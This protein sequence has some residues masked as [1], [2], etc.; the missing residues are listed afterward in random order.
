V[1]LVHCDSGTP[2]DAERNKVLAESL[3]VL[4]A[5][6]VYQHLNVTLETMHMKFGPEAVQA[7]VKKYHVPANRIL[8]GS[9]HEYHDFAYDELGGVRIIY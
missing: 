5:A 2:D 4:N 8:V 9:L 1:I 3:P 6:G 7:A